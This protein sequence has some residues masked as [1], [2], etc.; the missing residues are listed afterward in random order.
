MKKEMEI[1][2]SPQVL[3][4]MDGDPE[5]AKFIK[6]L[7]AN[8]R[9]AGQAVDEGRYKTLEDAMLALGYESEPVDTEDD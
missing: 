5:M 1:H 2:F 8:F 4:A 7:A 6:E 9:Q 3:A